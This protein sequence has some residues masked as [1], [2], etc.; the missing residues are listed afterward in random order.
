MPIALKVGLPCVA[1]ATALVVALVAA[2]VA[3]LVVELLMAEVVLP[4][5]LLTFVPENPSWPRGDTSESS[6]KR[7]LLAG[8]SQ[9]V[10]LTLGHQDIRQA[11]DF[12]AL[13]TIKWFNKDV[14]IFSE[15][16]R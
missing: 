12:P 2:L 15:L 4:K 16:K 7:H 11:V 8:A 13:K 5:L 14:S 9:P 3:E 1:L 10:K 6:A